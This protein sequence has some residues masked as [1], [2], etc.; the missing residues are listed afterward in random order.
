MQD[1][2]SIWWVWLCWY[3]CCCSIHFLTLCYESSTLILYKELSSPIFQSTWIKAESFLKLVYCDFKFR[4][5]CS[6]QASNKNDTRI[7]QMGT[8]PWKW[9]FNHPQLLSGSRLE[10]QLIAFVSSPT[11]HDWFF[12]SLFKFLNSSMT[13]YFLTSGGTIEKLVTSDHLKTIPTDGSPQILLLQSF[14][15]CCS[16]LLHKNA[17]SDPVPPKRLQIPMRLWR[18]EP[19]CKLSESLLKTRVT[20]SSVTTS[21]I[22]VSGQ[23]W[24][25]LILVHI[26]LGKRDYNNLVSFL[27]TMVWLLLVCW[28]GLGLLLLLLVELAL[29]LGGG[30]LVL[31]VLAHLDKYM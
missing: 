8:F 23:V 13:T 3:G 9:K 27:L 15:L 7:V 10:I 2:H 12:V 5:C 19:V 21:T 16:L 29:V 26:L 24:F 22:R 31:L 4:A 1:G 20:L 14:P 30:L 25:I 28:K 6:P 18:N 11:C 17:F